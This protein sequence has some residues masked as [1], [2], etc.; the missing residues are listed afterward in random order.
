MFPDLSAASLAVSFLSFVL[1]VGWQRP[2]Y[3]FTF[4]HHILF[5]SI[6]T[7]PEILPLKIPIWLC[8]KHSD[9]YSQKTEPPWLCKTWGWGLQLI[10]RLSHLVCEPQKWR[11]WWTLHVPLYFSNLSSCYNYLMGASVSSLALVATGLPTVRINPLC[12]PVFP[13]SAVSLQRRIFY[14]L[15]FSRYP[16]IHTVIHKHLTYKPPL[17]TQ[18]SMGNMIS[19]LVT[20][21]P[22]SIALVSCL[23]CQQLIRNLRN[24]LG[25]KKLALVHGRQE[26]TKEKD[27]LLHISKWEI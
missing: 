11:D 20:S 3:C 15:T 27:V 10:I 17:P 22:R 13:F 1:G 9:L 24:S 19:P 16:H 18:R 6:L 2:F 26:E 8:H 7:F 23:A 14:K 21:F 5:F 25:G 12:C 4:F